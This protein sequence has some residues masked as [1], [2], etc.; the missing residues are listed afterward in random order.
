MKQCWVIEDEWMKHIRENVSKVQEATFQ[1][2][3]SKIN[4]KM[5]G[6]GCQDYRRCDDCVHVNNEKMTKVRKTKIKPILFAFYK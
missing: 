3:N 4:A 6:Y 1:W 5:K 2:Y